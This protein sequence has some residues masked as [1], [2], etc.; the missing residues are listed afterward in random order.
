MPQTAWGTT[1]TAT[2]FVRG[3][4]LNWKEPRCRHAV[5]E[6]DQRGAKRTCLKAL[7]LHGRVLSFWCRECLDD[8]AVGDG[9]VSALIDHVS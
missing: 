6:G 9:A 4:S 8:A 1:A 2:I 7:G 5:A 3:A